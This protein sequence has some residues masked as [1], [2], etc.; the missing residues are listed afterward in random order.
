MAALGTTPRPSRPEQNP[1][2]PAREDRAGS[3]SANRSL[4]RWSH[5][6]LLGTAFWLAILVM[7]VPSVSFVGYSATLIGPVGPANHVA[8]HAALA[9]AAPVSHNQASSGTLAGA[10]TAGQKFQ[11]NPGLTLRQAANQTRFAELNNASAIA[12]S[13]GRAAV[14]AA[15]APIPPTASAPAAPT[16]AVSIPTGAF[17]GYIYDRETL[18]ALQG[19]TV[20]GYGAAGQDC[21][22]TTCAPVVSSANGSFTVF[23]PVGFDYVQASLAYHLNNI[24]Y[25]TAGNGTRVNVGTIYLVE[26]AKVRGIV[27]GDT[28]PS[29]P[30]IGGVQV[31]DSSPIAGVVADPG[32]STASNGSF[33]AAILP[34]P[35]VLAFTPPAGLWQ[36]NFTWL[37]ATPG[38][39]INIGTIYLERLTEVKINVTDSVTGGPLPGGLFGSI[40]YCSL[41]NGCGGTQQGI[42]IS[43][44][45]G[46]NKVTTLTAFSQPGATY[47]LIEVT[48]YVLAEPTVGNIPKEAPGHVYWLPEMNITPVGVVNF[49]V[50]M[51]GNDLVSSSGAPAHSGWWLATVCTMDGL[52]QISTILNQRTGLLNTTEGPC[53]T[54]GCVSPNFVNAQIAAAPLRSSI[55]IDPDTRGLCNNGIPTWPIPGDTPVWFNGT[56]FNI[57][58]D[59]IT[60]IGWLNFTVGTYVYGNVTVAGTTSAPSPGYAV[61]ITSLN[62]PALTASYAYSSQFGPWTS[63]SCGSEMSSRE[64]CA[65]APPGPDLVTVTANGYPNNYTWVSA[66]EAY[67]GTP[68]GVP[69]QQTANLEYNTVN[70]TAGGFVTGNVTQ[71]GTNL[72]LA[73]ASVKIC[74]VSPTYPVGCSS[75]ASNLRGIFDFSAPLGWDYLQI[76]ASEYQPDYVWAYVNASQQTVSVG[77]IGLNPLAVITGRVVDPEG[78]PVLGADAVACPL[79]TTA[80]TCPQLGAGRVGTNGVYLGEVTG[81]WLPIATYK[82]VV[83]AAGYTSNWAWVNAT[84]GNITN[85]STLI[86]YPSGS[87]GTSGGGGGNGSGNS[88]NATQISTWLT[89]EFYDNVTQIGVQTSAYLVC[90]VDGSPCTSSSGSTNTGGFFNVTIPAG[91]YYLNISAPGY[92]FLSVYFNSS[93]A[94]YLN[95]GTID[96]Q[97]LPWLNGTV[98]IN[99]WHQISIRASPTVVYSFVMG[100]QAIVQVCTVNRVCA[101]SRGPTSSVQPTGRFLVWGEPGSNDVVTISPSAPGGYTSPAGGFV[102]N[103]TFANISLYAT[104]ASVNATQ[105]LDIFASVSF[106]VWNNVSVIPGQSQATPL[107]VRYAPVGMTAIGPHSGNVAYFA[108]G[109]GNV[110]FFIP[111]GNPAKRTFYTAQVGGAWEAANGV[112]AVALTPGEAVNST[113]LSLIH[114]GWETGEVVQT[115][116]YQPATYLGVTDSSTPVGST[117]VYSSST[118]TNGAGFFNISAAADPNVLFTVGPG[119]DFNSTKFLDPVNLSNTSSIRSVDITHPGNVTLDHWGYAA[120]TQVNYSQFPPIA[121]AID[122]VKGIP[123]WNVGVFATSNNGILTSGTNLPLTNVGGQFLVDAPPGPAFVNFSRTVYESNS[124][125]LVIAPGEVSH[126]AR[127]NLT[128]DGVVA[129]LVVSKP[130]NIPVAGANITDC[131]AGERLCGFTQTN[132]SGIFWINATPGLNFINVTA[133]GFVPASPTL[134]NVCSDCFV[135]ITAIPVYQPAYISGKVL[136]LPAGFPLKGANV[137]VCS[138]TG[139]SP[140][141]PCLYTVQTTATGSFLLIVPAGKYILAVTDPD[142]N[143][144]YLGISVTPGEQVRVGTIFLQAFGAVTGAVY[145]SS[146]I[147][148]VAGAAVFAC[149]VWSGGVCVS[150]TTDAGGHYLLQGAPGPYVLTISAAG[151]SD[152]E[153][154]ATVVGGRTVV[155]PTAFLVRLGTATVYEV[156]G[157]VVADGTPYVNALVAATYNGVVAASSV[158]GANGNF[159]LNVVYGTYSLTASAQGE[160]PVSLPI[161]VHGPLSGLK[162]TL[163]VQTYYVTGW[164]SDGLTHQPLDSVQILVGT[165]VANTTG[166][167]GKYAVALP[168][169][170]TTLTAV[171]QGSSSVNYGQVSFAVS[172]NGG[173]PVRNV[174]MYPPITDVYGLVV[175]AASGTPLGGAGVLIVGQASDTKAINETIQT[176]PSGAFQVELPAG[177]YRVTG[178]YGGYTNATLTVKPSGVATQLLVGLSPVPTSSSH[179]APSAGS[180]WTGIAVAL[181]IVVAA[182]AALLVLSLYRAGRLGHRRPPAKGA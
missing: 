62:Y 134:V 84:V 99:P 123:V 126:Y 10:S 180:A 114:Y 118:E 138:P 137:S 107:P 117:L 9:A 79:T 76:S 105:Y 38:I 69:L 125:H 106:T 178:I 2:S 101:P 100:P 85:V 156:S 55:F 147:G 50:G 131:L 172:V 75:G 90:P 92:Q 20:Q 104:N 98:T 71:A 163:S 166:T 47:A 63:W 43:S 49:N 173:G 109:A 146:S 167:D 102:T 32:A 54:N 113:S 52:D 155:A 16:P 36:S 78:N 37:N 161:V 6:L 153:Q 73:L 160:S 21:P 165:T 56:Y 128:G 23:G 89:G 95:I 169:G 13:A 15:L 152:L 57:T 143:S 86:L 130:G 159:Q 94:G 12:G 168:N 46:A 91:L 182:G 41:A 42:T 82:V 80:S 14:S 96:L 119:N 65:A 93:G 129:A 77:N 27:K 145:D 26:T 18:K 33:Q 4:P 30:A 24:T 59:E 35:S 103:K 81:G 175:D 64:F 25:A 115:N 7:V 108:N 17:Y 162:L 111:A 141:G 39:T 121:G 60:N 177:T 1:S 74:S 61:T 122:V 45:N 22:A 11:I 58:P 97:P 29:D 67:V 132:G 144:T 148:P 116:T 174:T 53:N 158:T 142:Y 110:T 68:A 44:R 133:T 157:T 5:R 150:S 112:V 151:Y 28:P 34:S 181:G 66:P 149:P 179:V 72:G 120:S 139:G 124:T 176:S 48:G 135:H 136:G 171:Y 154:H 8:T 140:T 70:V 51:Y 31:S 3:T 88:T 164:V 127:V 87:N 83:S 19:A 40:K 170:T